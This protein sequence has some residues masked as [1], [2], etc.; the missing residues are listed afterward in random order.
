MGNPSL[1]G[2]EEAEAEEGEEDSGRK[3]M[4][5]HEGQD[6]EEGEHHQDAC[7][8]DEGDDEEHEEEPALQA[9]RA[10]LE[11]DPG[12]PSRA[13]NEHH[14]LTHLPYRVWCP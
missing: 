7:P 1:S 13:W 2:M 8:I 5:T 11:R 10:R 4:K 9:H 12:T 6:I 3:N 14:I